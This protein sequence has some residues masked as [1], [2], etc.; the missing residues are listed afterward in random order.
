MF[1]GEARSRTGRPFVKPQILAAAAGVSSRRPG[2]SALREARQALRNSRT[3]ACGLPAPSSLFAESLNKFAPRGMGEGSG[4]QVRARPRER[5]GSARCAAAAPAR[6]G[7]RLLGGRRLCP[8]AP[9]E[10]GR[11]REE[12]RVRRRGAGA[13]DSGWK[14]RAGPRRGAAEGAARGGGRL[15]LLG[16]TRC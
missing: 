15:Y 12:P 5:A 13:R 14:L 9:A 7:A 16:C 10:P 2:T 8:R 1:G 6:G 4:G 11:G 3:T